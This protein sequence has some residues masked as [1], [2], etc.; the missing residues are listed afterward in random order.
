M[1]NRPKPT[2]A[3]VFPP[4]EESGVQ[5]RQVTPLSSNWYH[6][7]R[8]DYE[9]RLPDGSWQPQMREAYDRGNGA[10]ILLYN[11]ERRTVVLTRQFRLPAF[12]NG[13]ADGQMIET[14]AGL[15]DDDA[16]GDAIR[17]EVAEETGYRI[18]DVEPVFDIFMSP[19]SVTER[20]HF[21]MAEYD[22]ADRP[23][24][25]GG[26]DSETENIE[27]LEIDFD[28]ALS[29]VAS[30]AIVDAKTILLLYHARLKEIL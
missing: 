10:T 5:M 23:G 26:V 13:V 30:G 27:V 18:G 1:S 24:N 28:A 14:A 15:L 6:L 25:G 20:I 3:S 29:M 7:N 4:A 22:P 21:F 16:P 11:R 8:Y 9:L 17:R 2:A 19:G 12:L